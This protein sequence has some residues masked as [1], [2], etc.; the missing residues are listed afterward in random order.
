MLLKLLFPL[1]KKLYLIIFCLFAVVSF[2]HAAEWNINEI[3]P[4]RKTLAREEIQTFE[5]TFSHQDEGETK[6]VMGV[7][8]IN[9]PYD[10]VWDVISDWEAQGDFVPGLEYFKVRHLFPG[11]TESTWHSLVEGQL[12]IPFVDFRYTLDARFDKDKGTMNWNLLQAQDIERFRQEQVDVRITDEKS[13]KNIEGFGQIEAYNDYQTIYYYAPI[14]EVNAQVPG[15][16]EDIISK[17]SLNRYLHAIKARAET[18]HQR[19]RIESPKRVVDII[20]P[21]IE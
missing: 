12:D 13:L 19:A 16:V 3:T 17:V 8:L 18:E 5:K 4:D 9:A 15:F 20:G 6:G 21:E 1:S 7:L 2:S 10:I 14:V 11:G